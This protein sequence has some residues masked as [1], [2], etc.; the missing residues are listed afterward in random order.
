VASQQLVPLR[1]SAR[2]SPQNVEQAVTL[3]EMGFDAKRV[4]QALQK[5]CD[6]SESIEWLTSETEIPKSQNPKR[7]NLKRDDVSYVHPEPAHSS[8]PS[9]R[10]RCNGK[11]QDPGSSLAAPSISNRRESVDSSTSASQPL[12]C[13]VEVPIAPLTEVPENGNDARKKKFRASRI[14]ED[15]SLAIEPQNATVWWR[16]ATRRWHELISTGSHQSIAMRTA[17]GPSL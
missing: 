13:E 14:L 12:C 8:V 4:E 2:P 1:G 9:K 7:H 3:L 10:F 17:T 16:D 11:C 6:I 5:F 15:G